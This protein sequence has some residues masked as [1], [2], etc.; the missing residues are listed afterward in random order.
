MPAPSLDEVLDIA[1]PPPP[2]AFVSLLVFGRRFLAMGQQPDSSMTALA[3]ATLPLLEEW[4]RTQANRHSALLE[5]L[6]DV[7]RDVHVPDSASI[8]N[9]S[10]Q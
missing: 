9:P 8:T 5:R 10:G 1:V 2:E 6:K 3:R 4:N 7:R